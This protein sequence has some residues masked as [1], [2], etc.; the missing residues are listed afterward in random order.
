MLIMFYIYKALKNQKGFTLLELVV[1]V[2]IVAV[3]AL[4]VG[5]VAVTIPPHITF[6]NMNLFANNPITSV[7]IGDAHVGHDTTFGIHGTSFRAYYDRTPGTYV[8]DEVGEK[9]SR[10]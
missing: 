8:Y 4:G 6:I 7:T 5:P 9:W 3:L 10:L 1:V 2:A